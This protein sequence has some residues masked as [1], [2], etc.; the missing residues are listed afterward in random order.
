MIS[1]K[2][3][4]TK[5][6][7]YVELNDLVTKARSLLR[8]YGYR[9]LPVLDNGKLVGIVSQGDIL[10]ITSTKTNI[11]VDGIMNKNPIT[12]SE[13]E[14]IF[15]AARIIVKSGIKQLIVVDNGNLKGIV[16]SMDILNKFVREDYKPVKTNVSEVMTTE[17]VYCEQ[18]DDVAKIWDKMY[19]TGFGG[20]PVLKDNKVIGIVT[21][22]D[23]LKQ[24][25]ARLSRE[26]GK[27]RNV[28]IKK[29]MK[30]PAITVTPNTNIKRVAGIMVVKSITRL[31]VVDK[32]GELVGIVDIGDIFRAYLG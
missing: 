20:F 19:S 16:S 3:I 30:T 10:K 28:P 12:I 14:D 21:R 17:V 7:I 9:S 4:M 2:E 32:K 23:A 1:V 29:V 18:D 6:L 25:S 26:S 5:K 15:S 8:K 27:I 24:G 31:P 13:D 11:T 22:V